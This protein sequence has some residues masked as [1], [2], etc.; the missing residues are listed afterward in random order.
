MTVVYRRIALALALIFAVVALAPG[1]VRPPAR[2][3]EPNIEEAISQ[4]EQM[5]AELARQRSQLAAL[6][7]QEA[8]LTASLGELRADLNSVGVELEAA[9][10]KLDAVT[11]RLDESRADLARYRDQIAAL[12]ENLDEVA[13]EIEEAQIDLA[14]REELLEDHLRDA[15]EQSQTSVLEVLLSTDTFGDATSQLSYMLTM[16]DEDRRLAEEIRQTRAQLKVRQRTLRDGR[17]T[18]R[19]L[20]DAEAERE[21]SLEVQQAQVDAARRELKAYQRQLEHL[22]ATQR[23]HLH[24]AERNKKHTRRLLE[25][26]QRA[27]EGQRR[28]VERLRRRAARLDLAYRGRFI[29]PEK[30]SFI[31]TQ[32]FGKTKFNPKHT[33][34]DMAYHTPVCGG[35]IYAAGDGVVLAD[36]RPN[37]AYGDTAIG[38]IIGHSQRLQ[39]WY[40]HLSREVVK[41][42]EEVK[43]GDLLGYEGDTGMS[44][45]CHLHFEVWFDEEPVEPRNYLP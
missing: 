18:L 45:G 39:T 43:T 32:E 9:T 16:S 28:L 40:W 14:L 33:G 36:G 22:R 37:T 6:R 25:Q 4:Q 35:K 12:E 38:V 3:D 34:I 11:Q 26:Q 24:A 29:W 1:S 8:A 41:V 44:T 31:V 10:R 42:G 30:G 21:A 19:E 23:A 2:A 7:R 27:L 13:A 5:E 20:R 15:Y 17:I